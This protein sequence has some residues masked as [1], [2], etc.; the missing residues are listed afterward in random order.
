ML[1]KLKC[2]PSD[3]IKDVLVQLEQ[4]EKKFVICVDGSNNIVGVVTNKDIR[5]AF[6]KSVDVTDTIDQIYNTNFEYLS[7]DSSFSEVCELFRL[8]D[9]NFLPIID[10]NKK[11][12][13]VLTKAQ[14]HIVFLEN[15]A[16]DLTFDFAQLDSVIS[17]HEIYNRP[18][19]FYKSTF[20]TVHALSLIH[21]S[22]PTRPY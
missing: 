15:I 4:D 18:W 10:K 6:L 1:R 11:L 7:V 8:S 5:R 16:F 21:I 20:L 9:R 13:N 14:F 12:V 2:N 19:G 17:E 3:L 22:E